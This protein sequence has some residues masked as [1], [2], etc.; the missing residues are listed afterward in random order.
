MHRQFLILAG[1]VED[2][3]LLAPLH[4]STFRIS[5]SFGSPV[6]RRC[7]T[8]SA[9]RFP[10]SASK[11]A[12]QFKIHGP[13]IVRIHQIEVPQITALI[14]VRHARAGAVS[15]EE[16]LR[17]L[18]DLVSLAMPVARNLFK[19]ATKPGIPEQLRSQTNGTPRH[20]P[21]CALPMKCAAPL[22]RSPSPCMP[23][24]APLTAATPP[25]ES[26]KRNTPRCGPLLP[27]RR[28]FSFT[29]ATNAARFLPSV[30]GFRTTS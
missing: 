4:V 5:Q 26:G 3:R 2:F 27:L 1:A 23:S 8:A 6:S 24:P 25:P 30:L 19:S 10:A 16:R 22:R 28:C 11:S 17:E 7:Q 14:N 15:L 20:I 12:A 29:S 18:I 9:V 21:H 13:T